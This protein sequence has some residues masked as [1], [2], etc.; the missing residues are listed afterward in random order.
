M[1]GTSPYDVSKICAE[2]VA[3]SYHATYAIP[4]GVVRC[5]NLYGGGDLHLDRIVPGTIRAL[6]SGER[7]VVR[8]DGR[9]VREYLYADDAARGYMILAEAA[10]RPGIAGEA[11]NLSGEQPASVLEVVETIGRLAGR[12]DLAPRVLGESSP[13]NPVM[14]LTALKAQKM[15]GWSPETAL[16]TGLARTIAWYREAWRAG[17]PGPVEAALSRQA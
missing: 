17:T 10:D 2:M 13:E 16:E 8:S 7:P 6:L 4:V 9:A 15:L 3:R 1:R 12:T 11:F 5:G 14:S